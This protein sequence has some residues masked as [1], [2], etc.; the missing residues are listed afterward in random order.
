MQPAGNPVSMPGTGLHWIERPGARLAWRADGPADRP[1]LLLGNSLGSDLA[2]WDPVLP[3]WLPHFRVVRFD[4]RG[5]GAS[6]VDVPW[7]DRDY[8]IELLAG[9][10]LAVADAAGAA[11]FHFLG[12][13]VGGM[14]GM[15]LARHAPDRLLRLVLSNTAAQLPA[16]VWAERIA[17]VRAHGML[18]L[19]DTTMQRW[20]TPAFHAQGDPQIAAA[21]AAFLQVDPDGYCGCAAAIRDMDLRPDLAH[22]HT[23]TLVI[24]G[25]LDPSTPPALGRAILAGIADAQWLELPVAHMPQRECPEV[26]ADAVARFLTAA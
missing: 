7:R 26:Y 16:D 22:I 11:R 21:R 17:A 15:W 6:L 1:V 24:A 8:T 3:Q 9:D 5:H 25:G 20:F 23:P 4:A 14:L 13:S 18:A 12:L 10:A 19:V 2:S